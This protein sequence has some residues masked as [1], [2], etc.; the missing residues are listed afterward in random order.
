MKNTGNNF[1]PNRREFI[2]MMSAVAAT[3]LAGNAMGQSS[4][5]NEG[6]Q[7][8]QTPSMPQIMLG[9]H[10]ISRIMCGANPFLGYSYMGIH[11]DRHMKE[12]FTSQRAADLITSC[13]KAGITAHQSSSRVDY[14]P[15]LRERGSKVKVI[16][17]VSPTDQE[18]LNEIIKAAN[19]IALVH[20]GGDTDRAF[21]A[22][23]KQSVRDFVKSVK[24]RGIMAGVSSHNPD[25]VKQIAD[26]GW[27]NDFF[28]TC[29]YWL[30]RP[31][32]VDKPEEIIPTGSYNFYRNDPMRMT[33]VI[34]QVD[35]T[36]LGFKILGA[37]RMCSNEKTVKDAFKFA[38]DNIK[39]TD[40]IIVGMFPWF[41][42]EVTVNAQYTRELGA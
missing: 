9:Q 19:S 15:I 23:K 25:V 12:Y 35:K 8:E 30:T 20:H 13:E 32:P 27:E 11:A 1:K 7:K 36:C 24:D 29:F 33:E 41:F 37:G 6:E 40:G 34:R 16:T 39:P 26:E 42:D 5:A 14:F 10:K 21:A 2:S 18:K 3:G 38:F 22:G 4:A 17:L 28:M 31:K